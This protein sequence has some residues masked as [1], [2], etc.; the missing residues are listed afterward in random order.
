ML[1][2]TTPARFKLL[3]AFAA[4][5][6]I[7]GSTYLAIRF[8]I[9]TL[10]PFLMASA[11][12]LI[13]GALLYAWSRLYGRAARP[14]REQWRAAAVVGVLLLLGGNGLVVWAQTRVPSGVAALLIGMLPCWMVLF[15]WL[16]PRGVRPGPQIVFGLAL[17]L[18]GLVW[19]I[20][21]D[22]LM[23]GGRVDL[24]GALALLLAEISWAAG[25][26]YSRHAQLPPAPFLSTA[27]Q[28]LT[29]SIALL[30][31]SVAL[32][33]PWHMD[34]T[35]FSAR[36]ILAW[37]YLIVFGSIVAYSAY[38]WL[39]RASTP[40]RVSTYAYVN[41]VIAVFLGWLLA[42]EALTMRMLIAAVVIVGGV[43]LITLA[44]KPPAA[45]AGPAPE[46]AEPADSAPAVAPAKQSS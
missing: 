19:L 27:M 14:T 24:L 40:A 29:G 46:P 38:V 39:L 20:G 26:I 18:A 36:S 11:R 45:G 7:W 41:P 43:V 44:P 8:A 10:P 1:S 5:Y 6:V 35:G 21:P 42:D 13:A 9:E 37:V 34:A 17:G 22:S 15:D 3:T 12:F 2:E 16:R 32:G 28:M 33:E 4:I 23:G 25:S 30:F 31:V